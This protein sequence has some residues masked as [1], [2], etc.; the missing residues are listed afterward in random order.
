[1][2]LIINGERRTLPD[3][4]NVLE[5]LRHYQLE[6]KILVVEL[7]RII[8]DRERYEDTPLTN[9]DRVEIVHFVG[10]G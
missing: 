3:M 2:E 7:N 5:L 1:M 4:A 9:G 6:K 8:V 10:G